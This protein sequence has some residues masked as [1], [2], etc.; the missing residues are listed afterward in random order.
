[1]QS[2]SP[3]CV[4][5]TVGAAVRL[6]SE[7][8]PAAGVPVARDEAQETSSHG[9][10]QLVLHHGLRIHVPHESLHRGVKIAL[11]IAV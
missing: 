7:A 9:V 8:H 5:L 10:G 6:H 4:L 2:V 11:V 3:A 1:M